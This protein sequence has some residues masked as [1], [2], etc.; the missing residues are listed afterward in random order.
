[1]SKGYAV[2]L[3][4]NHV[5]PVHYDGWDG[6]LAQPENDARAICEI[7]S[8][9]GFKSKIILGNNVTRLNVI[10]SVREAAQELES[11]DI[12]FFYYSG[13]GG[14]LPDMDGDEMDG[15]DET[16]CLYDGELV[17]DEL[18][19]LWSEF[20]EGVRILVLSDSCHSGTITKASVEEPA[21]EN[22][23][24]KAMPMEYVRKTY[25]KNKSFYD[26]LARELM[27]KGANEKEVKAGVLLISGCQD[28]QSSYAFTFDENS[29]FTT[30]LL[31]VL[32][33]GPSADYSEFHKKIV[34]KLD[35]RLRGKQK[36]NL[37]PTEQCDLTFLEQEFL[38]I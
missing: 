29:A 18:R 22:C 23:V 38:T 28:E 10:Y 16:W 24:K 19:L 13:H 1:M 21:L 33:E 11:G 27:D 9:R 12:F 5:D 7:A 32:E 26:N 14:Q 6:E 31:Q 37:Y 8:K 3:G 15:M 17:D 30:A 4:L 20:K 2:V 34:D 35:K 25:F 36:P